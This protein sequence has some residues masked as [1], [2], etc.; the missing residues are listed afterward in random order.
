M[1]GKGDQQASCRITA[2]VLTA[3]FPSGASLCLLFWKGRTWHRYSWP[4]WQPARGG[5]VLHS[6]SVLLNSVAHHA[7]CLRHA[8]SLC[9]TWIG[10]CIKEKVTILTVSCSCSGGEDGTVRVWDLRSPGCQR[11]YGSRAAVNTVVLHPNQGELISGKAG[12]P[13]Y[14][15]KQQIAF[16]L[17]KVCPSPAGSKTGCRGTDDY[18]QLSCT[19]SRLALLPVTA[20]R[21]ADLRSRACNSRHNKAGRCC[22]VCAQYLL[23]SDLLPL[24]LAFVVIAAGDQTG[25]I[26]VWDLTANACSCELVPEVGTAGAYTLGWGG[27]VG[28]VATVATALSNL[29]VWV[30]HA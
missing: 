23:C 10:C 30:H 27:G 26:R 15:W 24:L 21:I 13:R 19:E 25:H 18:L 5:A 9:Y 11:E 28:H 12:H 16:Q 8:D 22:A 3:C 17:Y 20:Q 29:L 1:Q 14:A 6:C 2:I 7:T 4:R